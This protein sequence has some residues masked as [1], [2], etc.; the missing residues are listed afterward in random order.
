MR[1]GG[2]DCASCALTLERSI[3]QLE[4]VE[5]V[6]LSFT[7]TRLIARGT[8]TPEQIATRVQAL[9]YHV[10][11]EEPEAAP[12]SATASSVGGVIGFA[13]FLLGQRATAA[14]LIGAALLLLSAP[15]TLL[16]AGPAVTRAVRALHLAVIGLAG[17]PIINR[18]MRSLVVGHQITID[19]LMSIATAGALLIGETGE[20]ATVIV[21]FAIGEALEGY[22]AERARDSLRG[23]LALRP[24]EAV[25]LRPCIDC[26]EHL[27]QGGYS[28]GPCPFCGVHETAVPV[29][30]VAVGETVIARPGERIAVDGRVLRGVS[31]VNQA[32]I[33]GESVPALKA[34]GAEVFAGTIN[35]EGVLEIEALRPAA[36]STI[37]QIVRLVEQAQASRAPVERFVDRFARWYTPAVVGLAALIAVAPPLLFG[38]PFFDAADGTR[39]WLYRALA[40]L[41][42]ACP[43]ALVISTPVTVVSALTGLAQRGVLVKGG[44]YLDVL[45]RVRAVAFD[46]TGTLTEGRPRVTGARTVSCAPAAARCAACDDLLALA[47]SVERRSGHPLAR[48]ILDEAG[49]RAVLDRYAAAE[50]VEVLAGQGVRGVLDGAP[51][52]VGSHRYFHEL[53]GGEPELHDQ[54]AEAERSGHTT[55]LVSRGDEVLGYIAVADVPRPSSHEALA[56]LKRVNGGLRTVMLTGDNPTVA[57]AVAA[58]I[59]G[60]D[61]VRADLLPGDKVV[62]LHVLRDRYGEVAMVGDGINDAPAL[63]AAS[64]GVAMGGAG[65]AQAMETA[66]VVLMAD[67]LARLP[68]L[69]RT[70]RRTH[71]TIMQNIIFS[72]GI[73]ALFLA[74]TLP[75][76]ATLWMA[77][78][79]DMGASLIV[80]LNGMRMLREP[81]S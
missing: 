66:D 65:T 27:G 75:G 32:P 7:T 31:S 26:A 15:L 49:E 48:A 12:A 47:V 71:R 41:I 81:E 56:A 33:T 1:I 2:M 52:L 51:V 28:G 63:A 43:C 46:K 3:A 11:T 25:V 14:A 37:S 60:V 19:L 59:G 13:H 4:G 10:V 30:E 42:V 6:E 5:S 35:G 78:F 20:A 79:A 73:K 24:A 55:M 9:G 80:T 69:F 21:L 38:A 62:A 68:D 76:L 61:E 50:E 23:L 16:E 53:F 58:Q 70:G 36:E 64:V 39:G 18:G 34:A 44:A 54:I 57:A 67:D 8:A 40:L 77:V 74:L 29:E 17:W 22:S 45:A 72:L